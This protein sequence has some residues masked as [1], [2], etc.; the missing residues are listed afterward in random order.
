[1][2]ITIR[3]QH[4]SVFMSVRDLLDGCKATH[5]PEKTEVE[6]FSW[7]MQD[8]GVY[9]EWDLI[10]LLNKSGLQVTL[11]KDYKNTKNLYVV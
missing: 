11:P 3:H 4:P 8:K 2:K 1:M 5:D 6:L 10:L 7:D 9:N